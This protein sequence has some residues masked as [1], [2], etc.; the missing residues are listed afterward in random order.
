MAP[1]GLWDVVANYSNWHPTAPDHALAAIAKH[2]NVTREQL[3]ALGLNNGQIAYR[4]K[5]GRLHREFPGIYA[6]GR[7]AKTALERASAAVL[8][9]GPGAALSHAA[10]LALWG[11]G[12][13]PPLMH[14]SLPGDRR[15]AGIKVHRPKGLLGR[16]FRTREGIRVTSPA[17]TILDCAP[18]L[19]DK[20]LAR[21]AN[22]A[23]RTLG[24]RPAHL[25]D[26][27]ARFPNHPGAGRLTEFV[28]VR[29]G[30]TRSE[31]ED[32]FPKFCRRYGLPEP[33]MS[34]RVAGHEVDALFPA[35][36]VIVELDSW[37]FHRDRQAFESDRKRDADGLDAGYETVRLTW[38]RMHRAPEE[39]AAQLHRILRRRR[40]ELGSYQR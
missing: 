14:V 38:E 7:P 33:V 27:I 3:L 36:R 29:G 10:A 37:E 12:R 28:E 2:G 32:T 18:N 30:P 6:V 26:V 31:W 9:C 40:A 8:A 20:A 21:A 4:I 22:E 1:S 19:S 35:E 17:R 5:V 11:L 13:W 34:A 15:P 39:A 23:R 24:L 25:A 16:D